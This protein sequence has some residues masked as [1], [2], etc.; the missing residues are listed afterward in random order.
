MLVVFFLFL[1]YDIFVSL[2]IRIGLWCLF[3]L[4]GKKCGVRVEGR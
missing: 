3:F 4:C 1:R 2:K